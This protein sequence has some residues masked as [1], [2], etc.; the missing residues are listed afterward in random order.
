MF[1]CLKSLYKI[2]LKIVAKIKKNRCDDC[3]KNLYIDKIIE[4]ERLKAKER[5]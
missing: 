1:K 2:S 3:L 4:E 5:I